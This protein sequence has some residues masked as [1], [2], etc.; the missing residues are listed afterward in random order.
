MNLFQYLLLY[1]EFRLKRIQKIRLCLKFW[2]G[3]K[4][5]PSK[6]EMLEDTK[7]E[8][9]KQIAKGNRQ[10]HLHLLGAD[11]VDLDC[12]YMGFEVI[13]NFFFV[14]LERLFSSIGRSWGFG[15]YARSDI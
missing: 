7:C 4:R 13:A 3:E 11:Q 1:L 15:K 12:E 6:A 9:E 10:R 5:L 8:L 2:S 14:L